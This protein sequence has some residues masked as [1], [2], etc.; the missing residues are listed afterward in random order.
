VELEFLANPHLAASCSR[1]V[2]EYTFEV[3]AGRQQRCIVVEKLS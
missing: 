3:G 2:K 1:L